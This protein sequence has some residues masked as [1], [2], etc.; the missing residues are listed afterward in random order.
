[1]ITLRNRSRESVRNNPIAA[2]AVDALTA[3]IVGIGIRPRLIATD[4]ALRARVHGLWDRWAS[5][6]SV[7]DDLTV[8]GLQAMAVRAMVESGEVFLRR[9]WRRPEDGLPVPM[10]VQV[11]E[12][13]FCP[14]Y[15]L[16]DAPQV[17]GQI[18]QGIEFD[19]IDRR[20]AVWLYRRHP[21]EYYGT[22][23]AA[24]FVPVRVP[25]AD[26]SHLY[27]AARPG[28]V[29]GLPVLTPVLTA[30][31]DL[32]D[33]DLCERQRKKSEAGIAGFVLPGDNADFGEESVA[34]PEVTDSDGNLVDD[35][36]PGMLA[37]LRNGKD[38]RFTQ[39][40]ANAGY[41][42]YVRTQLRM[43]AAGISMPYELFGDLSQVNYSSYRAGWVEFRRRVTTLQNNVVIP[44]LCEP[45]WRWFIEA[46]VASGQLPPGEYRAKWIPPRFEDVDRLK[47]VQA[48]VA[49][50]RAGLRSWRDAVHAQGDDP[51]ETFAELTA[52]LERFRGAGVW[53]DGDPNKQ[54]GGAA[55]VEAAG[56]P[57]E[58]RT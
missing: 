35:I 29:R 18:V 7:S 10:Q 32:A 53:I 2:R 16:G 54:T 34:S 22:V 21:G 38:I 28:Q 46:C 1:M 11:L 8:Y 30:L 41:A 26:V 13:D 14:L 33:Y 27:E 9:R 4:E 50:M 40:S 37:V 47:E 56:D 23:A 51:D 15:Q 3:N 20:A 12:S 43:I 5:A 24:S 55:P 6:C 17:G 48:S 44:L 25:V 49:E 52:D 19:A 31:R 36:E 39:P 57:A 45:L 42:D 58:N